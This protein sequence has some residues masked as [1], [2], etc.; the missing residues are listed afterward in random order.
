[1]PS[2]PLPVPELKQK[3][4][5]FLHPLQNLVWGSAMNQGT[6]GDENGHM[7]VLLCVVPGVEPLHQWWGKFISLGREWQRTLQGFN[8]LGILVESFH[9]TH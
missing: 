2:S 3:L 7:D 5:K 1:M 4:Q 8:C 9:V 6:R